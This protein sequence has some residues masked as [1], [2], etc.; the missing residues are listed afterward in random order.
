MYLREYTSRTGFIRNRKSAHGSWIISTQPGETKP[1]LV[2]T[3]KGLKE[4]FCISGNILRELYLCGTNITG[5]GFKEAELSLPNLEILRMKDCNVVS[6]TGLLEILHVVGNRL[7]TLYL[8]KPSIRR[9]Y[10]GGQGVD[11]PPLLKKGG[12]RVS[13]DRPFLGG[14]T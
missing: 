14:Q 2:I 7:K 5:N 3:D 11:D 13:F 9:G 10:R 8:E 6:E 1:V 4:I 12:S